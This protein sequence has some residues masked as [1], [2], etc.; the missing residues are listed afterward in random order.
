MKPTC[1]LHIVLLAITLAFT[2]CQQQSEK[3]QLRFGMELSGEAVMK[4]ADPEY[5]LVAAIIS[6]QDENGA[7]IYDK[8][9]LEL[10]RFGEGYMT[11]SMELSTGTYRLTEFMLANAAGEVIWATP[12][13]GSALAHL[14]RD[15]LPQRFSIRAGQTTSQDVQVIRIGDHPREISDTPNFLSNS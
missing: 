9:Y 3:G 8:E 13:E 14:V 6:I 12:A 15:P 10:I 1:Q 7:T 2:A 5:E 11:R 4:S